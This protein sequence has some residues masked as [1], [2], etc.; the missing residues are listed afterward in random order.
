VEQLLV[1]LVEERA[2]QS[3]QPVD[4]RDGGTELQEGGDRQAA[5]A[6]E[7]DGAER[8]CS[9]HL[10]A[11]QTGEEWRERRPVVGR[12]HRDRGPH[13]PDPAL[14]VEIG[15]QRDA[16]TEEEADVEAAAGVPDEM[17]GAGV[18]M[19]RLRDG[20]EHALGPPRQGGGGPRRD[21]VDVQRQTAPGEARQQEL[22]HVA[23]VLE[24]TQVGEAEEARDE[25]GVVDHRAGR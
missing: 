8:Q 22:A 4:A 1:E 21:D 18:V 5:E 17:H 25:V 9:Q 12:R 10:A 19:Q 20:A 7:V 3:H 2:V 16:G 23:E 6:Q 24:V 14:D 13:L 11:E 15:R